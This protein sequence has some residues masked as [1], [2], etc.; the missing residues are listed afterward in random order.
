MAASS[1]GAEKEYLNLLF[2][3]VSSLMVTVNLFRFVLDGMHSKTQ[4]WKRYGWCEYR[5]DVSRYRS[6]TKMYLALGGVL[7]ANLR[8]LTGSSGSQP[9]VLAIE[10]CDTGEQT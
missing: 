6:S 4:S 9:P 2:E 5:R 7:N 1:A 8:I 10:S 3:Y